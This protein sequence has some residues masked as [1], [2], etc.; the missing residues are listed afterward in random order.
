MARGGDTNPRSGGDDPN[1]YFA[2]GASSGVAVRGRGD[3]KK[4][5][6]AVVGSIMDAAKARGARPAHEVEEEEKGGVQAFAGRGQRLGSTM[7][8]SYSP[9]EVPREEEGGGGGGGRKTVKRT[10]HMWKNGFSVD[11]GPLRGFEDPGSAAFLGAI[12]AGR[13]PDEWRQDQLTMDLAVSLIDHGGEDY[14]EP[15]KPAYVAFGGSGRTLGSAPTVN[16]DLPPPTSSMTSS[17]T[18]TTSTAASPVDEAP[19][20]DVDPSAPTTQIQIRMADGSRVTA[21]FNTTHTVA[22][23]YQ[24]VG[25]LSPGTTFVL[26]E[27]FPPKDIASSSVSLADAGLLKAAVI[28][29]MT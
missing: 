1:E 17:T 9:P 13:Y 15:E 19:A 10:L 12:K 23:L 25:N 14:K 3:G 18:T 24:Y 6:D 5:R 21:S 11:E 28:Q 22:D 16:A 29:R 20:M 8:P 7:A 4:D 2:G 26:R 27:S